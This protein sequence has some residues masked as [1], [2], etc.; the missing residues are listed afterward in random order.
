ML[1]RASCL[2]YHRAT[3]MRSS[4]IVIVRPSSVAVLL[5]RVDRHFAMAW[6]TGV[7]LSGLQL[8]AQPANG[9]KAIVSDTIITYQQV[10]Q[11]AAQAID[12]LRRQY[13]GQPEEFNRK[14]LETFNNALD[15]LVERQLILHDFKTAGYK[16]PESVIDEE[17][18]QRIRDRFGD[19]K[20]LIKTLQAEG[21]TYEQFRDQEREQFII[22]VLT[23][24]NV[25]S[26][27]I[28]SPQKIQAYYD[29]HRQDFSVKD[30][31][32]VRTI[33]LNKNASSP[34]EAKKLAGEILAKIKEGAT[35]RE[36][37]SVYS[38]GALKNHE[39]E[40]VD[41]SVLKKEIGDAAARLNPG[42][43]SGVIEAPEAFYLVQLEEKKPAHIKP[44]SEVR[45][46]IEKNLLTNEQTRLRKQWVERLKVKT[47]V[48]YF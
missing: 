5:R 13:G 26:E 38:E 1:D 47:F 2:S 19:R 35:F 39:P 27:L 10:E 33:V 37:A 12:L 8:H 43:T 30:Q 45:D 48:R 14:A 32:K 36:M 3:L 28:V 31:V 17:I 16:L 44:L 11:S 6:L 9:I 24:K 29:L 42:E 34:D 18:Q 23:F 4:R 21:M 20:R 7:L 22:R 40:W 25:S 41:L 15:Q 46:E